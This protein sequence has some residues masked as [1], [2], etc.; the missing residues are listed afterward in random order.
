MSS[1]RDEDLKRPGLSGSHALMKMMSSIR[2]GYHTRACAGLETFEVKTHF[3]TL[4]MVVV[5]KESSTSGQRQTNVL[6]SP[7]RT[8]RHF[9]FLTLSFDLLL[10]D[11][12]HDVPVTRLTAD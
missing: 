11:C 9:F 8:Y 3:G 4:K 6:Q 12:A 5:K 2:T 1:S 10:D 7:F